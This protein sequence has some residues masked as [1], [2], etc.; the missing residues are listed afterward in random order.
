MT[1]FSDF[2]IK[3]PSLGDTAIVF[4]KGGWIY[5]M[6]FDGERIAQVPIEVDEDFAIGRGHLI[7]VSKSA[8]SGD[9]APD[10]SRAVFVARGDIFTVPAKHGPTRNLTQTPGVHER[11][12]VGRPTASGSRTSRTPAAR[13]RFTFA[14]RT[15]GHPHALDEPTET[16]TSIRWP[17][18]PTRSGSSG[19]TRRTGCNSSNVATKAVTLVDQSPAWEIRDYTWAPDSQW[20]AYTRP[21]QLRF[22]NIHLYSLATRERVQATDGWFR[23]SA[24]EFSSD[25]KFLFFLSERSF[26]PAY[27]Q[28]EWN[29]VYTDM[30]K[31]YLLTLAKEVKSPFAPK[32]DEVK[33]AGE[34][35]KKEVKKA[36][37][38]NKGG[39]Q[40]P[41]N[42][43]DERGEEGD[44]QGGR[45]GLAAAGRR[46]A[47]AGVQLR[48]SHLC[49][50]Q[51]VLRPQ[52]EAVLL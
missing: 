50:R 35:E 22:A 3:F 7:D 39:S 12:A 34:D 8:T 52:R 33:I 16:L 40:A 9:I 37:G 48:S 19:P 51:T 44:G 28:T 5:R 2:D 6:D 11:E 1:H 31:I 26:N 49:G 4:E 42:R 32:S 45:G 29:H 18:R 13:M 23:V 27:G 14:R 41:W 46:V 47:G 21:E 24:P 43:P 38:E 10:G 30:Q 15:A 20:I 25:G 36:E 17:G